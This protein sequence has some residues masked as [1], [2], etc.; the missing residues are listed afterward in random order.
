MIKR[1]LNY[2][3]FLFS[4]EYH[5]RTNHELPSQHYEQKPHFDLFDY[6]VECIDNEHETQIVTNG[7]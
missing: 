2:L 1:E 5:H 7:V 6:Q 3:A 4:A